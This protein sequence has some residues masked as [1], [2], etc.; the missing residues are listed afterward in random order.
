M[1]EKCTRKEWIYKMAIEKD[2]DNN[3]ENCVDFLSGE[4]FITVSFTDRKMINRTK[5]LYAERKDEFKYFVEN[6]DGSVCAKIPKRWLKLNPGSVP[7]PN[8]PKREISEEQK[9]ALLAGLEKYRASKK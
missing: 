1:H 8:K 4:H 7:D 5:K 6:E 9:A 3:N 2:F